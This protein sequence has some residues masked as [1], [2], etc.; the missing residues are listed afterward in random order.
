L[1]AESNKAADLQRIGSGNPRL[2][3]QKSADERCQECHGEVG[4]SVDDKIPNHAGQYAAYLIKQ[5]QNFQSGARDHEIMNIMAADLTP[6]DMNDIA[7]YFASQSMMQ[8]EGNLNN[9]LAKNI[10]LNGDQSREIPACI[11]CHGENGKGRIADN[12][13]YPVIGG[14]RKLY[15]LRQLLNWRLGDRKNSP[16]GVMNKIAQA[17]NVTEIEALADYLAGL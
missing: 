5:L 9:L 12:I 15:L 8:D 16:D 13:V 14:Q 2:G 11:S 10:V 7:A 1:Y 6:T 4:I 3:K 17:L